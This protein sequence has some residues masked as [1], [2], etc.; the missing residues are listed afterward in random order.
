[1]IKEIRLSWADIGDLSN[2][3]EYSVN[4]L[5]KERGFPMEGTLILKPKA[6]LTYYEFHDHKTDEIVVQWE[7]TDSI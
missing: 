1:M 4:A 6:V 7:D 2:F 5:L 3:N